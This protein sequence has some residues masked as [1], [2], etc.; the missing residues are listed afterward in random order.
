MNLLPKDSDGCPYL[1]LAPME[2]VGDIYFRKTISLVGG[3][4]E[5]VRPFVRVPK[6]AHIKSLSKVYVK[7]EIAPIPLTAQLIGS[8][9]NLMA[10]MAKE[11]EKRGSLRID[12]NC[13]CPSNKV[14]KRSAGATLLKDPDLLFQLVSALVKATK[15]P[16]T[17]KMRSGYNDTSLFKENLL[18]VQEA[19][20]TYI[21]LHPRTKLQGYKSFANWDLIAEAKSYLKIPVVGNGDIFSADKALKMLKTTKCDALMIGRGALINP[22]IFHEIRSLFSKKQFLYTTDDL[23]TYLHNY[24]NQISH[25]STTRLKINKLKQLI[26]FLFQKSPDLLTK[27]KQFL[28]TKYSDVDTVFNIAIDLL[29]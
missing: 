6:N 29:S 4:N 10:S 20:A 26:S 22:F 12:L 9:I 27:Q 16:I 1:L 7:D 17:V 18:A 19:K 8:D 3:F 5:A 25:L 23:I 15:V 2:G 11:M 28:T 21:T 14:T 13:G 24:K